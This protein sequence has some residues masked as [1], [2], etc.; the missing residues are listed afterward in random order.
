MAGVEA[1]VAIQSALTL[2]LVG[3]CFFLPTNA[4]VMALERSH[5]AFRVSMDDVARAYH[6]VHAA[7]R[8]G[9]FEM[10]SEF[11]SVRDRLTYLRNHAELGA[12]EPELLE[13]AAQM[14]H[15]SRDLAQVYS[16]EK[17]A[18]ARQFLR[19][20]E[21]EAKAFQERVQLAQSTCGELRRW[22]E[23]VEVEEAVARSQLKR[24]Q[25]DLGEMLPELGLT[26]VEANEPRAVSFGIAA[27]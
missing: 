18:R 1:G 20:R 2:L 5:R 7:D 15:E 27:E 13:I 17:V 6:G 11:D 3:L 21:E 23:N 16:D 25:D 4:R 14:S 24:L 9:A 10:R 12:L 8:D 19:Q 22:L 26:L